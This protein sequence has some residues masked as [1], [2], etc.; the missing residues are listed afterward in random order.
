MQEAVHFEPDRDGSML[1]YGTSGSGKS[2]VLRT[3]A[4]AAA[5][6][7]RTENVEVYGLDFGSGSLKSLEV[8]PHVGSIIPGD[9][10]ER[11]QRVLRTLAAVLD[12]RGK[13]FS[14]ANASSVTEYRELTGRDE[15]R[16]ILLLDG[17]P[18]FRSEWES[19]S[20]R[21]PFYQV[22]MRI[23]GEGRPLGVHVVATAD[24]SGSVPTAVSSN[25]SRRVILR[26]SDENAYSLLNA[27]KDVLDERSGPGRAIVDG[28]ETQIAV[29]G[30][31][32]NVAEQT[33]LLGSWP[34]SCGRAG[35]ARSPRSGRCPPAWR[36]TSCPTG[37]ASSLCS[38][39]PR[40][41]SRRA[42]S[43]RPARSWLPGRRWP[44]RPRR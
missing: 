10:A 8:L 39:S 34:K 4:I 22:F 5:I 28:F 7:R 3:I 32:P 21:M 43:T 6:G 42:A 12:D 19:T 24:R 31:T 36:W 30:G 15:S 1:V 11:V 29:L 27:P 14:A 17:L 41:R 37:S 23:L 26:L 13:R 35:S 44:A 38:A 9:D 25:V 40:T 16:I 2:T 18:Q 20:A 33:K